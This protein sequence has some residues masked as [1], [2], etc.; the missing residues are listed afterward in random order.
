MRIYS[1]QHAVTAKQDEIKIL[2][3]GKGQ[4]LV[5]ES[6]GHT[7]DVIFT[8]IS[9]EELR[10]FAARISEAIAEDDDARFTAEQEA[11]ND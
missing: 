4:R 2:I 6:E 11:E 1:R 3:E 7:L 10:A 5:F 9:A 8:F